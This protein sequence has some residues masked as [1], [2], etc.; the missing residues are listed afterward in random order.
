MAGYAGPLYNNEVKFVFR[1]GTDSTTYY[2]VRRSIMHY[3]NNYIRINLRQL[4]DLKLEWFRQHTDP[5]DTLRAIS[6]DS[7]LRIR[8]P[9]GRQP[10]F[11][12]ITWMAVGVVREKGTQGV[13]VSGEIWINELK[14]AGIKK[15]NGWSSRLS[16]QTQWAD[17]LSLSGGVDYQSGDF[18]TMTDTKTSLGDS[19]LSGNL[20]LSTALDKFMPREWGV[21][22]PV[23]GSITTALSRPQL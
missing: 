8:A 14:I 9:K 21:S 3:W 5:N 18:R 2:E 6:A 17:F 11:S 13:P 12:N 23:G 19:K 7:T 1:F 4:S 10:N 22:I 16:L 20:N 15:F